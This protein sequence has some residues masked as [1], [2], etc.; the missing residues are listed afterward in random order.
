[1]PRGELVTVPRPRIETATVTTADANVADTC[2]GPSIVTVH[3]AA[4][5]QA[6]CQPRNR[7]P[8]AAVA[9][10]TTAAP[11]S[12][13]IEHVPGHAMPGRSLATEPC[14]FPENETAR[15]SSGASTCDSQGESWTSNQEP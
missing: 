3:S 14:P 11:C 12:Q 2:F 10:S 8:A 15:P 13:P 6:P 5:E 7:E 1:M 4:P 9:R